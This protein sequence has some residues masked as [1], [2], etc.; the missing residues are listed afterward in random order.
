MK[1]PY[2][3]HT[4]SIFSRRLWAIID[5]LLILLRYFTGTFLPFTATDN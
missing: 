1:F 5:T 3:M 4:V 2:Y